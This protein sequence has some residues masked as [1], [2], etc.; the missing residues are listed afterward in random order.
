MADYNIF[1]DTDTDT[2]TI[3]AGAPAEDAVSRITVA[4]MGEVPPSKPEPQPEQ[5]LRNVALQ[6]G[7]DD[8]SL[9]NVVNDTDNERLD[10]YVQRANADKSKRLEDRPSMHVEDNQPYAE[11]ESE[12][13]G[14]GEGDKPAYDDITVAEIKEILDERGVDYGTASDKKT[15]YN[16]L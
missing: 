1:F 6:Q 12:A 8:Y 13:E 5:H 2:M 16:K 15:L 10:K 4:E 14:E 11:D 9:V 7:Y 3:A